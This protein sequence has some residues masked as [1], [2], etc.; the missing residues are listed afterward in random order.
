MKL[1]RTI[2]LIVSISFMLSVVNSCSKCNNAT[3]ESSTEYWQTVGIPHG[4]VIY[5]AQEEADDGEYTMV[6][7]KIDD[8]SCSIRNCIGELPDEFH[9][10]SETKS[11]IRVTEIQNEAFKNSSKSLKEVWIPDSVKTIGAFP[12]GNGSNELH[13]VHLGSG[14]QNIDSY[15]FYN[16]KIDT[17]TLSS[18][19]PYFELIDS[20]Y[21]VERN[22]GV[23]LWALN[24]ENIPE[25][26]EHI[27]DISCRFSSENITVPE[28]VKTIGKNAF[29]QCFSSNKVVLPDSVVS[30]G[31]SAFYGVGFETVEGGKYADVPNETFS[32]SCIQ[33]IYLPDTVTSI[34]GFAFSSCNNLKTVYIPASVTSIGEWA[35]S[36]LKDCTIICAA[37]SK[38]DGWS[39]NW[40]MECEN[41]VVVFGGTHP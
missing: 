11:G 26:I 3:S 9:I 27:G 24:A 12:F 2:S 37:A 6:Y 40:L 38:P 21:L 22:T 19:N 23:L 34:G 28:G 32:H 29:I 18:E 31:E 8:V 14:V 4:E 30:I 35:F 7:E 39:E 16:D 13:T 10:P 20:N 41:T 33:Y 5:C 36:S 15:M 17:L 1:F 25:G